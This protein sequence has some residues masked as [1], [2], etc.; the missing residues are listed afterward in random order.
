MSEQLDV[1]NPDE[2]TKHMI[3]DLIDKGVRFDIIPGLSAEEY[4]PII[5]KEANENG[6]SKRSIIGAIF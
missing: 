1:Y 6:D 2:L 3:N 4:S 5:L